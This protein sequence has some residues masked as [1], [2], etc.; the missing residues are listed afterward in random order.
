LLSLR[1]ER[2]DG[3]GLTMVLEQGAAPHGGMERIAEA[4]VERW[5]A[6]SLVVPVFLKEPSAALFPE[7][8]RVALPGRREHFLA[9]LHARRLERAVALEGEVVL[10]LHSSGWALGPRPRRGV[11]VVAF[12]NGLPRWTSAHAS[13]Y[14]RDRRLPVRLAAQ[15]ALPVLRAHQ[16]R[17]L[18]RADVVLASSRAAS[19]TLPKPVPVLHS[20]V[21]VARFAGDGNPD[22]YALAV[23]RLMRHKRFDLAI[24]AMRG[25][26]ERLVVVG[27]GPERM[28]L[29]RAA[30][31]NVEFVGA[32]DDDELVALFRGARV[33][34]HPTDEE[35]G[36]VMGEALAAGVPVIAPRAGGAL[37]IVEPGRT[38]LLLD[39]V[40]PETIRAALDE[41]VYDPAACRAA[42]AP[43]A[44]ERFIEELAGVLDDVRGVPAPELVG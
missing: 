3:D 41:V 43:F 9:P 29:R 18:S 7:A 37:E 14:V 25:R 36:I 10:A 33:L 1:D 20:P 23:G 44:T 22:G 8:L 16:R 31:P 12:T 15:A 13:D 28:L 30:G 5:P 21:D 26:S 6:T 34:V 42:A 32:V 2:N 27:D 40:T 24:E 35:F 17:L 11:P 39:V 4:V 38:G 19:S